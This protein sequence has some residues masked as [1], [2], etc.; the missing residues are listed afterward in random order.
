MAQTSSQ[1]GVRKE[2]S[3]DGRRSVVETVFAYHEQTKHHFHR[4]ARSLGYMDW[5]T[6]PHPFRH[7]EGSRQTPLDL[8]RSPRP[9]TY[10]QLYEDNPLTPQEVDLDSLADLFRY[11][12]GLSAW[13]QAGSSRWAL[14]INPS[15]GNL[16]STEAYAVLPPLSGASAT[17]ALYHYLSESHVL[18]QRASFSDDVWRSFA[19]SLPE[20]SFLVGLSSVIW[21]EAWKYGERA[22]RYCQH[23]VGHAVAALRFAAVFSGWTVRLVSSW[24]TEDIAQLLGVN[25]ADGFC[26]EELEEAELLAVVTPSTSSAASGPS[27]PPPDDTTMQRIREAAWYGRANQ[28]SGSHVCWPVIEEVA[29]ATQMPRAAAPIESSPLDH[30]CSANTRSAASPDARRIISQ[31]RSCLALDGV[32]AISRE[33]FIRMLAR[34]LPG[35]YPPWDALYWTPKIHLLLFVHRVVGLQPGV[36]I[37]IRDQTKTDVLRSACDTKLMWQ[38][39]AG[40]PLDLPLYLLADADCREAARALSCQQDIAADGFFSLG[41]L[42]EFAEP[43]QQ[44]GPSFYR[45]L[46]WE[47]G[48]IGQVLYLEAE[49]AGARSTGIGCFFDDP[50]HDVVGLRGNQFQ[51]LYHFTMGIPIE[52]D[53]LQL[54]PPY[55]ERENK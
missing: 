6:Q 2:E 8:S 19:M 41:M 22:F 11:S 21:R 24:S 46:F 37:L 29:I 55:G 36:Y 18:E 26:E 43:I 32:S 15:S 49:A 38:T 31:R 44:H 20:G 53:R 27:L 45:N 30:E 54:W 28:L 10:D 12:L 42:A 9:L 48:V 25:R 3:R 51:S 35:P 34:T 14:R 40:V 1:Q 7:Y 23:D 4:Y 52:D 17:P 16:H 5:A 13:K 33:Q 50:V 39:P 47:A